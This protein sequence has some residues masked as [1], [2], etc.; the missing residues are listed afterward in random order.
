MSFEECEHSV[1]QVCAYWISGSST[2]WR[3]WCIHG[4][5]KDVE[6]QWLWFDCWYFL[7]SFRVG[8]YITSYNLLSLLDN[9]KHMVSSLPTAFTVSLFSV[10]SS[11]LR[12]VISFNFVQLRTSLCI[13]YT[14]GTDYWDHTLLCFQCI[15]DM[16]AGSSPLLVQNHTA[17]GQEPNPIK[18]PH[19]W[20]C[21]R[22]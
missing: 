8:F 6:I 21:S 20:W 13:G 3:K 7:L 17:D 2:S 14:E 22:R 19:Y 16:L 9:P 12:F 11:S 10:S 18:R 15:A 1:L 5:C 4:N